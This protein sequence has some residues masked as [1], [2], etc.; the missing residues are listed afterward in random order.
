MV[1]LA[2]FF[3]ALANVVDIGLTI[4]MWV[5]VVRAIISWVNPDPYNPIVVFLRRSTD[6][7]LNPIRR[8]LPLALS[9]AGIDL[10]PLILLLGIIFLQKFLVKS[11]F[12][13]AYRLH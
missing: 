4:Y 12:E 8:R 13:L 1:F 7:I 5:V 2:Y 9:R 3:E 10:S 6:P 11:L